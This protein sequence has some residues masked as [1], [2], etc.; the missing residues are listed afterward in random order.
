MP[1]PQDGIRM[2]LTLHL[3]H[4]YEKLDVDGRVEL[5]QFLQRRALNW[6]PLVFLCNNSE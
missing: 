1:Q 2:T 6:G 3:H 4:V 5:M